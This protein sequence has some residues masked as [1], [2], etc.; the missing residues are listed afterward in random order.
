MAEDHPKTFPS[1]SSSWAESC[2][3][4]NNEMS[5][6]DINNNKISASVN[7]YKDNNQTISEISESQNVTDEWDQIIQSSAPLTSEQR[8]KSPNRSSLI[9]PSYSNYLGTD[10]NLHTF[11]ESTFDDP[12][13]KQLEEMNPTG[14]ASPTQAQSQNQPS[15]SQ[16]FKSRFIPPKNAT[17]Q[18]M[19][20]RVTILIRFQ[21]QDT[22]KIIN[23]PFLINKLIKNSEFKCL[24]IKDIR[25][26]KAQNLIAIESR[27]EL[28]E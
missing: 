20:K 19:G 17:L 16:V 18:S 13:L 6:S 11:L 26:N 21:T 12:I 14:P 10:P 5:N 1:S 4:N 27:N 2:D 15:G 3:E 8:R 25:S 9:P 24:Q 23:N 7:S 28:T 22:N